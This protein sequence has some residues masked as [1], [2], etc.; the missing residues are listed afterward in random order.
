LEET[1]PG[2]FDVVVIDG[3]FREEMVS[4]ALDYV[5][6]EGPIVVDNS[7]GYGMY[8]TFADAGLLRIDFYGYAPCVYLPHFTS[9]YFR[10]GC[11]WLS[12][13]EPIVVKIALVD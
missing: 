5:S 7:D 9:I 1:H 2:R 4:I 13:S 6:D 10:P 8:A 11:R 3:L 12:S